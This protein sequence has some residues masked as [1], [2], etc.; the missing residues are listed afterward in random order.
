MYLTLKESILTPRS[1]QYFVVKIVILSSAL[2]QFLKDVLSWRSFDDTKM[3]L[4][5]EGPTIDD[6][7]N[8]LKHR[9]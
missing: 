2:E 7:E 6:E 8:V 4:R 5:W 3:R 1:S 9:T